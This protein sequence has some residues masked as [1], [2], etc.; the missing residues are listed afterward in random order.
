MPKLAPACVRPQMLLW[1][2]A[3]QEKTHS[4]EQIFA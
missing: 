2:V 4:D 1:N 3:R